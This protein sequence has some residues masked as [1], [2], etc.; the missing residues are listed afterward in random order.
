MQTV[1]CPQC[2]TT[3]Q[4]SQ[5]MVGG[6]V[7]CECGH[8][9]AAPIVEQVDDPAPFSFDA[10]D[11]V[12]DGPESAGPRRLWKARGKPLTESYGF[13]SF[14]FGLTAILLCFCA[15]VWFGLVA[16]LVAVVVGVLSIRYK[17]RLWGIAGIVAGGIAIAISATIIFMAIFL[18]S[19]R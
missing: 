16:G 9:I 2:G 1:H 15:S 12:D 10:D 14:T 13:T 6:S 4:T 11:G 7:A 18:S 19:V 3:V 5:G 17:G 8:V